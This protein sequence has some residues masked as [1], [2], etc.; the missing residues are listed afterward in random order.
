VLDSRDAA[1]RQLQEQ[2]AGGAHE[3]KARRAA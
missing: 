3:G 2:A 1:I